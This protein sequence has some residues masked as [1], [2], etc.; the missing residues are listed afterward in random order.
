MT[1]DTQALLSSIRAGEDTELEL[2]EVVFH[3]DRIALGSDPG[4]ASSKLAEVF[5]SMANTRGGTLV[6][7]VRDADRVVVGVDPR[8]RDLLEQFVVN[9]AT[10]NCDPMIVPGLDWEYLPGHGGEPKLCLI[11]HVPASPFDA[12]QTGDGRFLQRI[13][14]HRHPIPAERLARTFS[15]SSL[16]GPVEERAVV[17]AT[18][19]ALNVHLLTKYFRS[20]FGDWSPPDDWQSTLV[21]HKLAAVTQ[22]GVAPTYLGM[23]LFA[24]QPQQYVRGAYIDVS[25]YN[26]RMLNAA[27]VHRQRITGPLPSQIAQALTYLQVSPLNSTASR[28][29]DRRHHDRPSYV[30]RSLQEAIVNAVVHRDYAVQGSP[31]IIRLFPDRIEF[32]NPGALHHTLTVENLYA[33]CHPVRRNQLLAD[34]LRAYQSPV[35]SGSLLAT[36]GEGFLN[37]VSDSQRLSGRRPDL[38]QI[39]QAT[40]LTIYAATYDGEKN[41]RL[42]GPPQTASPPGRVLARRHA[43][44][45][46]EPR[47]VS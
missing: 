42:T 46:E 38:T 4:R 29:D 36:M 32:Q 45:E 37:L 25:S 40:K 41:V 23:L 34:F 15:A 33:G 3:G 35:T 11:I 8:K 22:S 2:K 12:H 1:M 6:M 43:R 9:V 28:D 14:S 24:E 16:A 27:A 19:D 31:I 17:G 39:G 30:D 47:W 10:T 5:V 20:R 26:Q 21:A 7:G 13:G 18:L 44:L